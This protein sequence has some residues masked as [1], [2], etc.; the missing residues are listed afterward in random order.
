MRLASAYVSAVMY[1]VSY[2]VEKLPKYAGGGATI[3]YHLCIEIRSLYI[4]V[5]LT[6]PCLFYTLSFRDRFVCGYHHFLPELK[7]FIGT[8]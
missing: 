7:S 4:P 8:I 1:P 5:F 2:F 6:M 3:R